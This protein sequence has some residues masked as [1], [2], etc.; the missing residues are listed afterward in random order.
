MFNDRTIQKSLTNCTTDDFYHTAD[1]I[2]ESVIFS[3][4]KGNRVCLHGQTPRAVATGLKL[5]L[6]TSEYLKNIHVLVCHDMKKD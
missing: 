1:G 4:L 5:H 3:I 2:T 6:V